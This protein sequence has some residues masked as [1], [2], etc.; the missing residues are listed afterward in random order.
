[1]N[2]QGELLKELNLQN[3]KLQRENRRLQVECDILKKQNEQVSRT[4][5]FFHR[6]IQRQLCYNRQLLRTSPYIS[7][8][9]NEKLETVMA[10]DVFSACPM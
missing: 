5:Q 10:S 9:V 4:Q 1:M 7:V 8:M 2:E 6:E 3:K